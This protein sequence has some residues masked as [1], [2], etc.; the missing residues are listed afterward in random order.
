M[1]LENR[2]AII[3][4]AGGAVG[5]GIANAFAGEGARVCLTGRTLDR[6]DRVAKEIA[7]AGGSAETAVIDALD[8][9]AVD[10]HARAVAAQGGIHVSLNLVNR[11][12]VQGVPLA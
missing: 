2:N 6:L 1:L 9:D 10:E 7:E 4:G 8:E 11:G 3:Y 12:D 5:A